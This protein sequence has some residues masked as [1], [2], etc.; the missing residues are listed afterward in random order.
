MSALIF[1]TLVVLW[2]FILKWIVEKIARW[3]PDR[4]WRVWVKW[5]IFAFLMPL[6]LIDEIVGGWQFA[7]L[8]KANVVH[9]NSGFPRG[10]QVYEVVTPSMQVGGTFV[11]VRK[12]EF[13]FLDVATGKVVVSFDQFH[14]EGGRLFPGFDS[15]HEPL[16]FKGE[17][18]PNGVFD[19]NFI[20]SIGFI[21]VKKPNQ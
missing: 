10:Q 12:L 3:L 5:L 2:L 21:E 8:C 9:V 13:R 16:T 11:S 14:A 6:P 17:C 7:R 18:H 20:E 19:K 1:I 4:P 15:G